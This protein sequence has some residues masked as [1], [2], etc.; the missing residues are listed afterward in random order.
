MCANARIPMASPPSG[1]PGLVETFHA[2]RST[3]A[4]GT[5]AGTNRSR[6]SAAVMAPPYP[7]S[8]ELVISATLL[9]IIFRVVLAARRRPY[10]DI[11]DFTRLGLD[12]AK[13][14]LVVVKSGYLSPEL[15][16]L[17]NPN[18]MALTDGAVN[19]DIARLENRHRPQRALPYAPDTTFTA[20]AEPSARFPQGRAPE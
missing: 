20:K 2:I 1:R 8:G 15:A 19:Q 4:H 11:A 18:L 16:P 17:A 3:C 12:P 7:P 10:H 13:A 6:N 9:S 14:R 5:P